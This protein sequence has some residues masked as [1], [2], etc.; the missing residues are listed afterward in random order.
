MRAKGGGAFG[1]D[2]STSF[3][4]DCPALH[5]GLRG[6]R[7]S[8][9]HADSVLAPPKFQIHQG[10]LFRKPPSAAMLRVS[11]LG[12]RLHGLGRFRDPVFEEDFCQLPR[13][14]VESVIAA[15]LDVPEAITREPD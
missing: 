4:D 11:S 15:L 7:E 9:A 10:E 14:S 6:P 8:A 3:R 2:R 1:L 13:P 5:R 12:P